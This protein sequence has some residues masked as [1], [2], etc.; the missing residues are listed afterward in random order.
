MKRAEE[1]DAVRGWYSV[2]KH[3]ELGEE[4]EHVKGELPAE[5]QERAP[6]GA[7][8]VGDEE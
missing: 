6:L 4:V 5:R 2:R 7:R 1:P 3:L 8:V